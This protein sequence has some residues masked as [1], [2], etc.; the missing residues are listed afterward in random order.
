MAVSGAAH[1]RLAW[2]AD[3]ITADR[4]VCV[5]VGVGIGVAVGISVAAGI[6]ER[7]CRAAKRQ[8]SED[9]RQDDTRR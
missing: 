7:P 9:E 5:T 1:G 4:R 2:L 6:V 8:K 3:P